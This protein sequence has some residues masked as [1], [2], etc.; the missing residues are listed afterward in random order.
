DRP[1]MREL[2]DADRRAI[3]LRRPLTLP[4]GIHPERDGLQGGP[5][6]EEIEDHPHVAG[7]GPAGLRRRIPLDIEAPGVRSAIVSQQALDG[8]EGFRLELPAESRV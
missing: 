3:G 1:D 6:L 5:V 4:L 7:P 8:L 2:R